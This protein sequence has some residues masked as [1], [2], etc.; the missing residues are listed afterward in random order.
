MSDKYPGGLVTA[1]AP[2][3]YS[4]FFDGSGDF[5][6]RAFTSTTDGMYLQ[7]TTYTLEAWVFMTSTS[8]IQYVYSC[9]ASNTG[10]F[11]AV[12]LLINSGVPVFEC[13]PTTGGTNVFVT[14]GTVAA[15]TW[16][17]I[18]GVVNAGT[19][20]LYVNGVSVGTPTSFSAA[21]FTPVG[22]AIGRLP[23]GFG[24][25]ITDFTGYISNLRITQSTAVYTAAFTPPTQLFNVT[26]TSLLT[27]NSPAIV[28]QSSNN[29]AI[30]ANGNAAVSTFTPFPSSYYFYNA[31]TDGNTR[32]M[33]PANIAGF[34]PAYG[35]AAPGVWT[36]DQAQ[37]FTANRL[38]PIYDPYFNL[39][40]LMLPGNQPSG[41]TDIN[42]NVFKDSSTNNFPITRNGNTTQ[43]TFSPFSQTGWSNF[44][45]TANSDCLT[46]PSVALGTGDFTFECWFY[47]TES[48]YQNFTYLVA[49]AVS[50]GSYINIGFDGTANRVFFGG[51]IP[52]T[53]VNGTYVANQWT[54][55]AGVRSGNTFTL[56]VNGTS[57]GTPV[58]SANSVPTAQALVGGLNW[59]SGYA[60]NGYIS[61][62]RIVVGRAV[63]TSN[64]IPS[65]VPLGATSGGQNPPTGTQTALLTC[66]DNRFKDN[67]NNNSTATISGT[68]SVQAF[69]PF[70]PTIPYSAATVGGS[71][72]FDGT[73]DYLS[74]A[75]NAAFNF[76][77]GDFTVE[78]WFYALAPAADSR[79][80]SNAP[81]NN[82]GI[83]ISW[84]S[85]SNRISW[86]INGTSYNI[87]LPARYAW[88]HVAFTR[89]G[90]TLR[91][92][93]NGAIAN[94]YTGVSTSI[95]V[96]NQ[97]VIGGLFSGSNV[98]NAYISDV[99]LLKGTALYAGSTYTVPTAPLTAITNTS[100]LTNFTN[101]GIIDATSDN[102][103]ETVGNAQIST[104]QSR[105]GGSSISFNG[106]NS[107]LQLPSNQ[108]F[109][110]GS[111]DWTV[112]MWLYPNNVSNLQG[113]LSFGSNSWRLF[114][115]ASG[116]WYLS[117]SS[118]VIQTS[119]SIISTGQWYHIAICRSGLAT[120]NIK[121]FLNGSQVGAAGSDN[122]NYAAATAFIGSEGAGSYLNGFIDDLRVTRGFARYTANFVPPTSAL[123]LQ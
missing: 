51:S 95:T 56:Y 63:Y 105:F 82:A 36:L 86:Y 115:S 18:A 9:S 45:R 68:P 102:V 6:S 75:N 91:T 93:I 26:N 112:E 10:A 65:T 111:S 73:G 17:H 49:V 7:G 5:L 89:S 61:N 13:R 122:T 71:G 28:D 31:P 67:S 24:T 53:N 107:Y 19:A 100:L 42:N 38:W 47:A 113:L 20:R 97:L 23:N 66:Q 57:Q 44:F 103:L 33:V 99:R 16:T 50:G 121:M 30:T 118:S 4:V 85:G 70:S 58:T 78:F 88:N 40:T 43:G 46:F 74:I 104:A 64:F 98:T 108:T 39:T 123:Q 92:Y 37:Y 84:E 34:N 14:G 35:A 96:A 90:T 55:V 94:T 3:G 11:G 12:S 41:V 15:N 76:L 27:C 52:G 29:F 81:F 48:T 83:D 120:G 110:M 21:S 72:F 59:T 62:A 79:F 109:S 119:Q 25:G 22:A 60:F 8:G 87:P 106:T 80:I 69:S 2:A 32:N 114:L 54:H 116:L 117:G 1:A 77:T 101:A